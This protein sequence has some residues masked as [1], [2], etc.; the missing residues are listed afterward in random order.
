MLRTVDEIVR[1][2]GGTV[3][4]ARL[5]D[6]VPSAVSNWK[7]DGRFPARLHYRIARELQARGKPYSEAIFE[8][9]KSAA[10]RADH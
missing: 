5:F 8:E 9:H 6:V 1:E 7:Q 4:T 10:A 3:A 2:L